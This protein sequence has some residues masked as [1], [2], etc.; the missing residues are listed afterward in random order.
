MKNFS[1]IFRAMIVMAV[2]TGCGAANVDCPPPEVIRLRKMSA[3][4]WRYYKHLMKEKA[5]AREN[6]NSY[7]MMRRIPREGKRAEE[8]EE[9]DCPR[10]GTR[11][12]KMI[13]EKRRKLLRM[14]DKRKSEK[15]LDVIGESTDATD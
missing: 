10:P 14:H 15:S 6:A 8:I 1:M 2:L 12:Q 4:R 7:E 3:H 9:W 11:H 13:R 5:I